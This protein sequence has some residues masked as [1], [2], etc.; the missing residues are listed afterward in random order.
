MTAV[1]AVDTVGGEVTMDSEVTVVTDA[2]VAMNSK[3]IVDGVIRD[4]MVVVDTDLVTTVNFVTITVTV[5]AV[6]STSSVDVRVAGAVLTVVRVT[7]AE[8]VMY[9]VLVELDMRLL[10]MVLII[11]VRVEVARLD[12]VHSVVNILV[13]AGVH[14]VVLAVVAVAMGIV[15]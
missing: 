11:V 13:V 8:I 2:V 10:L 5:I 3:G 14:V 1:K 12:V 15:G 7:V 6:I 4:G 9:L